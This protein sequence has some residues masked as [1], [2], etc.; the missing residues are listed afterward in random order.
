MGYW[1][2]HARFAS[3][4]QRMA[5]LESRFLPFL[6][7][8]DAKKR[9]LIYFCL[10]RGDAAAMG[11]FA[12]EAMHLPAKKLLAKYSPMAPDGLA[13]ALGKIGARP[14]SHRF[15]GKLLEALRRRATAKSIWHAQSITEDLLDAVLGLPPEALSGRLVKFAGRH[16]RSIIVSEAIHL[17]EVLLPRHDHEKAIRAL[18]RVG[19]GREFG[20]WVSRWIE[21][22]DFPSPPWAGTNK[23]RPLV[24][25][26]AIRDAARRYR[27]CLGDL[28]RTAVIGESAFYEKVGPHPAIIEVA[29]RGRLGWFVRDIRGPGNKDIDRDTHAEVLAQFEKAGIR[30]EAG[31]DDALRAF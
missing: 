29:L 17:T 16:R 1:R 13:Q 2:T 6:L 22:A 8:C 31:V 5:D 9:Q 12:Q 24:S 28:V 30:S 20:N 15:Y 19:T 3:S 18:S 21:S 4:L 7:E 14:K 25:A 10:E 26:E 27:N 23:I 11:S